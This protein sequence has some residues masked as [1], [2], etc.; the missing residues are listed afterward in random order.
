MKYNANLK[1]KYYERERN[2]QNAY[3]NQFCAPWEER[4]DLLEWNDEEKDGAMQSFVITLCVI[5]SISIIT[6]QVEG[7]NAQATV[8]MLF[9]PFIKANNNSSNVLYSRWYLSHLSTISC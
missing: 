7:T 5:S 1:L 9:P 4:D 8:E 3:M 6:L 2:A